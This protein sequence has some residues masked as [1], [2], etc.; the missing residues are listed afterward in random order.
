MN[1]REKV[2]AMSSLSNALSITMKQAHKILENM[3]KMA[4]KPS[5]VS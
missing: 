1:I 3:E 5:K 2:A 4:T